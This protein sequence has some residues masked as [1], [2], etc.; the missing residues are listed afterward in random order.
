M[1]SLFLRSGALLAC[2]LTLAACGGSGGNLVLSGTVL[3]LTRDG[4]VL[5]NNGAD[6]L[7]VPATNTTFVFPTLIANDTGFNV[8]IKSSPPSA[9]CTAFNNVGKTGNY[10]VN[11]VV[12]SC[13][14][15]SY[16]VGGTVSGLTGNGLVL[17]N[18]AD[19]VAVPA[20][21]TSFT[22]TTVTKDSTGK[23]VF[24]GR[25]ADGAPYGITVLT[26]PANQTCTVANGTGTM[27]SAAVNT[28]KVSCV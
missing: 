7:V 22:L 15:N 21:A 24:A 17:I 12:I 5:Q 25:V 18:G 13:V 28:I 2:A 11:T 10:D 14:T 4:L 8:T 27:G 16:D 20:G 3:G 6:D 19:R 26:Q 23:D 1:K 9:V